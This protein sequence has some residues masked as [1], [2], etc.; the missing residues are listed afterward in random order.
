MSKERFTDLKSLSLS[1]EGC[2]D[3]EKKKKL[4]SISYE[5][6]DE[7]L[8]AIYKENQG[9]VDPMLTCKLVYKYEAP[10]AL[11]RK[12]MEAEEYEDEEMKEGEENEEWTGCD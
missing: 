5:Q 4:S 11:K 7:Q 3:L 1:L 2:S 12:R 8:N 10:V 9:D 6:R